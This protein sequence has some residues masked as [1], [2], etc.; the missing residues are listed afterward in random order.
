[1]SKGVRRLGGAG[2]AAGRATRLTPYQ[3]IHLSRFSLFCPMLAL[4]CGGRVR[5]RSSLRVATWGIDRSAKAA[6]AFATVCGHSGTLTHVHTPWR[7]SSCTMDMD[8]R[9]AT[10]QATGCGV[11]HSPAAALPLLHALT[12]RLAQLLPYSCSELHGIQRD[13]GSQRPPRQAEAA[14]ERRGL[15]C[16]TAGLRPWQAARKLRRLVTPHGEAHQLRNQ[17]ASCRRSTSAR[18][19]CGVC[20]GGA[21]ASAGLPAS[22]WGPRGREAERMGRLQSLLFPSLLSAKLAVWPVLG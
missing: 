1:M 11:L 21:A 10:R 9:T 6:A 13:A 2:C 4:T 18:P 3:S 16:R 14:N 12:R 8:Y 20:G 5:I 19:T 22:D 17:G 15:P 7:T